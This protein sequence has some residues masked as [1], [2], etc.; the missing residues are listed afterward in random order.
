MNR[1]GDVVDAVD[2]M[3]KSVDEEMS[4]EGLMSIEDD[5]LPRILH[6]DRLGYLVRNRAVATIAILPA[7]LAVAVVA[8]V[9]LSVRTITCVIGLSF[10]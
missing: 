5:I 4:E 9:Y 1:S 6:W 3:I 7:I 2:N 8:P 10:S